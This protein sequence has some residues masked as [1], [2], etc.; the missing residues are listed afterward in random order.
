M[1]VITEGT[2][3]VSFVVSLTANS[4]VVFLLRK[5]K[6][7]KFREKRTLS[8]FPLSKDNLRIARRKNTHLDRSG[9]LC[10]YGAGLIAFT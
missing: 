9:D 1:V 7:E 3:F 4:I 8:S 6:L 10:A 5:R 2:V